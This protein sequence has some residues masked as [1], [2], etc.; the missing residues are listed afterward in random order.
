MIGLTPNQTLER[1]HRDVTSFASANAA[2]SRHRTAR[3]VKHTNPLGARDAKFPC[4]G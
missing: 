2:L 1:M 3:Y 4:D